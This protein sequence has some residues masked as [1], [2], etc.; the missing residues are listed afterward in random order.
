MWPKN[1]WWI[2]MYPPHRMLITQI[3]TNSWMT[4]AH[5]CVVN[6]IWKRWNVSESLEKKN[7]LFPNELSSPPTDKGDW[8]QVQTLSWCVR[9]HKWPRMQKTFEFH[10]DIPLY[11]H[12]LV[13]YKRIAFYRLYTLRMRSEWD[14]FLLQIEKKTFFEM[15]M[16]FQKKTAIK[17]SRSCLVW[18]RSY[19][20]EKIIATTSEIRRTLYEKEPFIFNVIQVKSQHKTTHKQA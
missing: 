14:A 3:L 5:V 2:K 8:M 6:G 1:H 15:I 13:A 11:C 4:T 17:H 20:V 16:N 12:L 19:M 18:T 10:W 9:D 7:D